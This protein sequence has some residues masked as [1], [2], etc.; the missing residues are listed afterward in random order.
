MPSDH[1]AIGRESRIDIVAHHA[2]GQVM[3]LARLKVA[4]IDIRIGANGIIQTGFLAAG[5]SNILAVRRPSQ[6]LDTSKGLHRRLVFLAFE[7]VLDM[8]DL[9]AIELSHKGVGSRLGPF[10]PMLV[11]QIVMEMAGSLIQI[12]IHISRLLNGLDLAHEKQ[13]FEV[14]RKGIIIDAAFVIGQLHSFTCFG[15]VA[16]N[17]ERHFPH[18]RAT[19]FR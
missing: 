11:H 4:E 10:I 8:A 6:L 2:L 12:G 5:V 19:R 16:I 13:L 17:R 14:R 18:L 1:A 3:R 9:L 7:Q 15:V